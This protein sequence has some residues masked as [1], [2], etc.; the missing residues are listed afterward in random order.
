MPSMV[1][2]LVCVDPAIITEA[3]PHAR[4]LI[5]SAIDATGLSEFSDLEAEVMVGKQLLWLAI[6]GKSIEAAAT[7]RLEKIDGR[8]IC[9]L[10]ACAGHHRERWIPLLQRLE[11]FATAEGC[12]VMRIFG[13]RGWHRALDG[14]HV[15][16]VVLEKR[17]I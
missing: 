16:H 7:T 12:A 8:K 6:S 5:K 15:E 11:A 1:D 2:E 4:L 3:W 17:M 10:T 13:R 14:Y 9:V